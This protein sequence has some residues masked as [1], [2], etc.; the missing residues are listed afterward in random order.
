M[1]LGVEIAA[2]KKSC[3]RRTIC[4]K[5]EAS[6]YEELPSMP[7]ALEGSHSFTFRGVSRRI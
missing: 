2:A 7:Y 1:E 6:A 3:Q 5:A 4:N